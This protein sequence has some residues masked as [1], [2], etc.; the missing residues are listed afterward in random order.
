M[1]SKGATRDI[2]PALQK[3]R[4]FLLGGRTGPNY[5]RFEG[6]IAKRSQPQPNLP[7][8]PHAK[9]SA[10]YYYDRDARR[11]LNPPLLIASDQKLISPPASEQPRK[12]RTPGKTYAW[13]APF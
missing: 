13:D 3:F 8:G 10:N 7:D 2:I 5:L 9:L 11:I 12:Y 6:R 1:A 4:T